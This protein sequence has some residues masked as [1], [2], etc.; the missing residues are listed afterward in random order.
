[1]RIRVESRIDTR[2]R[3]AVMLDD[4]NGRIEITGVVRL[5]TIL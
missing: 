2:T 5:F 3:S 1:V 4:G